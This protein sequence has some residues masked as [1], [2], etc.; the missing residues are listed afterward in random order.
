MTMAA[1][2]FTIPRISNRSAATLPLARGPRRCR[3]P[4]ARVPARQVSVMSSISIPSPAASWRIEVPQAML[5]TPGWN[6]IGI[7]SS[8]LAEPHHVEHHDR[9]VVGGVV[10]DLHA[11]HLLD[12]L[13][14]SRE[15]ERDQVIGEPG[16][17]SRDEH[18]SNCLAAQPL[19]SARCT[20]R[21]SAATGYCSTT[22]AEPTTLM[23]AARMRRTS[24]IASGVR[25]SPM[26]Q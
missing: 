9:P 22:G 2:P 6:R 19:P 5:S 11:P 10:G 1:S 24:S 7:S 14:C 26:A 13:T 23:P 25:L 8:W 18:D 20:F 21:A 15:R 4:R 12:A 3:K 16:I 17:H